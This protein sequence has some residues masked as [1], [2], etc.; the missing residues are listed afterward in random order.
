MRRFGFLG[1]N[2]G[3]VV[4]IRRSRGYAPLPVLLPQSHLVPDQKAKH[5][6]AV[7][8]ELKSNLLPEHRTIRILE[9]TH[10]RHGKF[11]NSGRATNANL[12][13]FATHVGCAPG[14]R[15][16]RY[17]SWLLVDAMGTGVCARST[18]AVGQD[19]TSS[20]APAALACEHGLARHEPLLGICFDGTGYGT[21]GTIWGGELLLLQADGFE[22][23]SHL[24]PM[25]LTGRR[26][27][28]SQ[29][30]SHRTGLSKELGH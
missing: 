14:C 2:D 6:L 22:R 27:G 17:A 7:G 10:R 5:V 16:C 13:H 12:N 8:G 11:G 4:P 25:P 23:L 24:T 9:S 19:S 30:L 29:T 26:C 1:N 3:H 18:V 21:D 15:R 20:C 28:D